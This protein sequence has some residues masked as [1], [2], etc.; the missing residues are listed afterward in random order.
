MTDK[1]Y[2]RRAIALARQGEGWC[3][4]NPLVG[5]VIVKD[6]RIIGEGY[7]ARFGELHA[8]RAALQ[9]LTEDAAGATIYV[10]LEP[11]CHHG[12]QPPCTDAIIAAG[13]GRVVI[14]SRDPNPLVAG[15]GAA[16][17]RSHGILVEED[18]L[19]EECDR[20]NPAFF[21]FMTRRT[22]YVIMKAAMTADGKIATRTGA[23]Q[24]ISCE[25]SRQRVQ[26]LRHSCMGILCGIGTVLADD[27]RLTCRLPNGRS[28]ERFICD[29]RLRLPPDSRLVQTAKE[30]P[31]WDVCAVDSLPAGEMKTAASFP[32]E[33]RHRAAVL[34]DAGVRLLN[35]PGAQGVDLTDLM[36]LL[37]E[38]RMDSVLLEGGAALNDAAIRSGIVSHIDLFLAPL[39]F[40]GTAKSPVGGTGVA[41]P[42]EAARFEITD[43]ERVGSDLLIHLIPREG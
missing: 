40:G 6:G 17:L 38:R 4:P 10:T 19:K 3:H 2:M 39:I 32:V 7:H 25:A 29:S 15:K 21:H 14:G 18:F 28:P 22:P 33:Y 31:V 1:D 35:C 24:W 43:T 42:D 16:V 12:H 20:L 23:S 30:V 26:Q 5:A 9:S 36:R 37:G 8:E 27:P 41:V 13:L 34:L 11:C